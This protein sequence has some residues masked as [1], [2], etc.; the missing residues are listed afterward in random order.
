MKLLVGLA[1]D[2]AVAAVAA[3]PDVASSVTACYY[4]DGRRYAGVLPL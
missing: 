1:V 3:V 2:V 4:N